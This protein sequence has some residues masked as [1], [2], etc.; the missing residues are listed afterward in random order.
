[1]PLVLDASIAACWAFPDEQ[2]PRA[3]AAL[4]RVRIEDVVVPG[5]WWFEVRNILV[6]N[7]SRKRITESGTKS[8]LRELDRLRIRVDREPEENTVLRLART[9][10]LS[11]YDAS[12]LEL[13]VR[14]AIPVAT[15]DG[16]LAS[17][18]VAEGIE[19]VGVTS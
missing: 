12:Y 17:A 14:E 5:L 16:K 9:H 4:A 15:L 18:A 11:V 7:E 10:F 1:M 19:L 2:D 8:F 6:V 3:D 13:A